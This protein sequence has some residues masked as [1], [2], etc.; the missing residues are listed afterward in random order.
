MTVSEFSKKLIDVKPSITE[1]LER[2][3]SEQA[4]KEIVS[5]NFKLSKKSDIHLTKN[6][7]HNFLINYNIERFRVRN[8]SFDDVNRYE[9]NLL[10]VANTDGGYLGFDADTGII[11]NMFAD[12][13]DNI[14]EIFCENE[15]QFFKILSTIAEYN[16]MIVSGKIKY[17]NELKRQEYIDK[18]EMIYPLGSFD[19]FF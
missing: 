16:S 17:N 19:S 2:G 18:S 8:I 15:N 10:L 12:D 13:L 4:A 7:I 14:D 3:Y 5:S 6:E 1:V 9:N 11:Y